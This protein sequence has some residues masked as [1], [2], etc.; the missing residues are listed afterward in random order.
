MKVVFPNN[1]I[2]YIDVTLTTTINEV[3][4]MVLL[5]H[6]RLRFDSWCLY[7][8]DQSDKEKLGFTEYLLSGDLQVKDL[9]FVRELIFDRQ[10]FDD[11]QQRTAANQ[12]NGN[13]G[14]KTELGRTSR[15]TLANPGRNQRGANP[16][17]ETTV[18]Q[19]RAGKK[20]GYT[21]GCRYLCFH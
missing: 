17:V 15:R 6:H 5:R 7:L 18:V 20:S 9:R 2:E 4:Q 13:L 3:L 12:S 19:G 10:H 16:N 1:F 14:R 21:T 8:S 11:E